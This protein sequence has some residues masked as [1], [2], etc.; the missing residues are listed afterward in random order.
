MGS[1]RRRANP[2]I[3]EKSEKRKSVFVFFRVFHVFRV[4][5][6]FSLFFAERSE[7]FGKAISGPDGACLQFW[8]SMRHTQF[9]QKHPDLLESS[10]A[11]TVP[12][13]MHGDAGACVQNI[14]AHV[15]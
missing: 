13:G 11:K 1:E 2:Q 4:F 8:Q 5:R 14:T 10:W 15:S 6:F 3:R 12:L 9:V 7:D